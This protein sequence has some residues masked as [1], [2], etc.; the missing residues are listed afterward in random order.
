M[1]YIRSFIGTAVMMMTVV[2]QTSCSLPKDVQNADD[3][4]FSARRHLLTAVWDKPFSCQEV[5]TNHAPLGP[6]LGNGDVGCLAAT[7]YNSQTMLLSKVDFV[8]DGWSDWAGDGAAALPV[9]GVRV[10]IDAP[11]ASGFD[12][13]M[14][15]LA[16]RLEMQTATKVPVRMCS[17]LAAI[18]NLL[19]TELT[20]Q[21]PE[22][23]VG[24]TV[25]TF[26]GGTTGFYGASAQLGRNRV[27]Q[28][29]RTTKS[30]PDVEW[31]SR[32]GIS[33]RIIGTEAQ[34]KVVSDSSVCHTFR[35][36]GDHKVYVVSCVSGGGMSGQ[37]GLTEA[38]ARLSGLTPRRI[39]E[40]KAEKDRWWQD[41]W[42]RS[43]VETGDSLLDRYYLSS[44]YLMASAYRAQAPSCG[45]MYGVW[46]MDDRM[47]YHGDIHLNYN[48]QAGFYSAFSANR[49]ELVL[50]FFDFVERVMPDGARRAREEMGQMHPSLAGRSCRGLL[51]PVS[52]LGIGR[53]Y[54]GY[55]QQT[56]NAP[57]C[58][59]LFSWYYDYTGDMEFLRGRAYPYIRACG[60]FYEDY[61]VREAWN[62]SYRYSIR[63]GGHENS[64]DLNPPSDVAFVDLTFRLLL[65]YS[66]LL[67]VDADR[68]A[69][70]RDIQAHLPQY[71]VIQPTREPNQGLPVY[72]KN[73][74]GWDAPAHMIQ[75]HALYP[76]EVMDLDS[77]PESLQVARNTIYYY[78]VSQNGFTGTMNELGLSAFV[79]GARAGFDPDILLAKL[80]ELVATSGRNFLITDGHHCLE[81]T[82]GVEMIHS[83][84]LQ[85][86]NGVIRLFPNW[87]ASRR[88]SFTRLR[89][90]GGF[91]ATA[92]RDGG[93][94]VGDG[95]CR[96]TATVGGICRLKN[97]WDGSRVCVADRSGR[98]VPLT[99]D[100]DVISFQTERGETYSIS[101]A[102]Q[103]G[104][105]ATD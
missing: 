99:E 16:N 57:F 32:A 50:P 25:E 17:W 12:Y 67:N 66:E 71:K 93:E 30:T 89:A 31:V 87:P 9:G 51:F 94:V 48:S 64:W 24:V 79:M 70:W 29:T 36:S 15:L 4:Y 8:T 63:T 28:V 49:P 54:G 80:S 18:E 73:E 61:L 41:M 101:R 56:M 19:V 92:A 27:G 81:K 53:F 85:T 23:D 91:L 88:A 1:M 59:P 78:G 105:N 65:R 103:Y 10:T 26:A 3:A 98:R 35:I 22:A 75:L 83:M 58:I 21:D 76:C 90:K 44:I 55:W 84:M 104:N 97:P 86:V 7:A 46:N 13:R 39:N 37:A 11:E 72:A 38:C 62:G 33:T 5:R 47:M 82:A 6:F 40:A 34:L 74:D 68:R 100:G 60:D 95:T 77:D 14:D 42:R 96:L 45:G 20:V 52:A 2:L 102:A 43:Y 69:L